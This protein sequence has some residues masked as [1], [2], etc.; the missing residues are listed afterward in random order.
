L[1]ALK[2]F[3]RFCTVKGYCQTN[4]AELVKVNLRL[5]SH[6]QKETHPREPFTEEEYLKLL[7][8]GQLDEFFYYAVPI[9]WA[10]GLR[11]GDIAK[12]E[13]AVLSGDNIIVWTSKSGKR[14]AIPMTEEYTP[15][16]RPL[17]E[18]FPDNGTPYFFPETRELYIEDPKR[19]PQR[20]K[21]AVV[22]AGIKNRSFHSLRVSCIRRWRTMGLPLVKCRDWAGHASIETTAHY[23]GEDRGLL[24][25]PRPAQP[26]GQPR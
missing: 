5:L 16:L 24:T 8:S 2:S 7:N 23:T 12:L 3:F 14:I 13:R 19:L 9:A 21:T 25:V 6:E 22:A 4:P 15:G 18:A 11:L 10:C 1:L 26:E 17:L 20:F